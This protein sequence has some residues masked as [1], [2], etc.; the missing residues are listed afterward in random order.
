[1]SSPGALLPRTQI[2]RARGLV[3][4]AIALLRRAVAFVPQ[5]AEPSLHP[6]ALCERFL[7]AAADSPRPLDTDDSPSYAPARP[8]RQPR[9]RAWPAVVTEIASVPRR[10][11]GEAR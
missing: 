5:A 7:A 9:P 1:M 3:N 10:R 11:R 6:F 2:A 8:F 4:D